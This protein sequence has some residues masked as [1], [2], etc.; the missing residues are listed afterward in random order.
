MNI[1][2]LCM[3]SDNSPKDV[4]KAIVGPQKRVSCVGA[5]TPG[6]LRRCALS[7][8]PICLNEHEVN[9]VSEYADQCLSVHVCQLRPPLLRCQLVSSYVLSKQIRIWSPIIMNFKHIRTQ[10]S[11]MYT[12]TSK[13][14]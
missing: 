10:H 7:P 14:L 9:P 12:T 6:T 2:Q 5:V 3:T 13:S 4:K 11:N 1:L 8:S